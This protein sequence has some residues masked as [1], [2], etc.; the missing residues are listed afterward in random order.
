[1]SFQ[2]LLTAEVFSLFLV[3][4]RVGSCFMLLPAFGS[5]FV[6]PWVR[7][8]LAL[9][10]SLVMVPIVP[11]IPPVPDS[12]PLLAAY[13]VTEM[14]IGLMIGSVAKIISAS[15]HVAGTIISMQASLAQASMFDPNQASQSTVFGTFLDMMA[16]ALMFALNIHH[17]IIMAVL[18]S[19]NV[20]APVSGIPIAD[21]SSLITKTVSKSFMIGFQLSVPLI[22]IG[23]LINLAS[24]L[25]AR[26]MPSF[27]VF[28]V[29]MP[30]QILV[31]LFIFM[32]T[33]SAGMM[34][35]MEVFSDSMSNLFK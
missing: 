8:G 24:G 2:Q 27:Q 12:A 32:T 16:L 9:A 10:I 23:V 31:A 3:F 11:G 5:P 17:V 4:C 14:A 30:A 7:L 19:Y 18:E 35:Y 25:L 1:M 20:F 21:F 28:F 6:N 13:V 33:L 22:V 29:I 34:W 15:L 26:L